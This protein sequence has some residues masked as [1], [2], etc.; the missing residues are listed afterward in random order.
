MSRYYVTSIPHKGH[1]VE[2]RQSYWPNEDFELW[3]GFI[4]GAHVP[5]PP[6]TEHGYHNTLIRYDEDRGEALSY[7]LWQ[8]CNLIDEG[9]AP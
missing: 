3:Y 7:L 9:K 6:P 5:L 4:D 8:L 1:Q 2:V